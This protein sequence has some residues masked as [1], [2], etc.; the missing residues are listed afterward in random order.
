MN[1]DTYTRKTANGSK[2]KG[3]D[4]RGGGQWNTPAYEILKDNGLLDSSY[5]ITSSEE[6][7]AVPSNATRGGN[8]AL[9]CF[10]LPVKCCFRTFEVDAGKV[11]LVSDG[12]G[13]FYFYGQGVHRICDPFY[14]VGKSMT[15]YKGLIQHGDLTLCVVEQGQI[16]Y[17]L[18]QGQPVLLPPGLHQW[19]S[20]TMIFEKSFDLNNNVIRMGPLTLI[21]VDSGYSAVTEDNGEQK[22]LAGGS[23]YLLTH[24]NWKFQKYLPEKIQSSNLKR[25]EATSADNVLMAVDAT[26]IWRITDVATAALNSAETI[27]KDGSDALHSEL[28]NLTKLTNDVLKQAEASLAAFIGAVEYSATFNVAAAV[29]TPPS[30]VPV[31]E[32]IAPPA[33]PVP[34]SAPPPSKITSPLFDL[35]RLQTCVDHANAVT[36]TYGVTIISINV[37]AAVPAD[38]TL[39][40]SLAQG[41]V[42]AAEAQKFE[43]VAAGKAAA[44]KIEAKGAAEAEVLK[45]RGDA[46]AER[47]RAE[48]HRA[49]A[50]LISSNEVAVKLAT[51][52]HTGAALDKNKAFFFGADAKDIGSLLAATA[53]NYLGGPS[54]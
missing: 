48:G 10:C 45:A 23:T 32:G 43:T 2:H 8:L 13:K 52:D 44:A 35:V 31:V 34:S 19:R 21:T 29:A 50:E 27:H 15:Y 42:A 24:R 33:A 49:A 54:K 30:A 26:V 12:R 7:D 53:S 20:P 17:A 3:P 5:R 47:V 16:G 25:I 18:D 6:I 4:V 39:M 36:A 22:I 51:I 11:Q 28:G 9:D 1:R 37:V 40:V 38:K 14:K 46:D 41:A